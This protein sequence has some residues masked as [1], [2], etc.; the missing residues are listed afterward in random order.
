MNFKNSLPLRN[1]AAAILANQR[2]WSVAVGWTRTD[3]VISLCVYVTAVDVT[4]EQRCNTV[5]HACNKR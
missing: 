4:A 1:E 2:L 5:N 3:D